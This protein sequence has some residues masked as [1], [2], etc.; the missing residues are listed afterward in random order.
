M[1][2][3]DNLIILIIAFNHLQLQTLGH[4]SQQN[5]RSYYVFANI[6]C[7]PFFSFGPNRNDKPF[8]LQGHVPSLPSFPLTNAAGTPKK[9][10]WV[11]FNASTEQPV[12]RGR[13]NHFAVVG[14]AALPSLSRC[15]STVAREY[16]RRALVLYEEFLIGGLSQRIEE[17]KDPDLSIHWFVTLL[18]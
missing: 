12:Q 1:N 4:K 5:N 7:L 8:L 17:D 14:Q 13:P 11:Y 2:L 10:N 6:K 16:L 18:R 3:N 9:G 15:L